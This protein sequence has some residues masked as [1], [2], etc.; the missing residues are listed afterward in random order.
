MRLPKTTQPT[1]ESKPPTRL[2]ARIPTRHRANIFSTK[3]IPN[4]A[5]S[6]LATCAGDGDVK[7]LDIH[8]TSTRTTSSI[9]RTWSCHRDRAK[10]LATPYAEQHLLWSC[11][12]DGTVRQFDIRSPHT[13]T[14]PRTNCPGIV[15]DYSKYGMELN[16]LSLDPMNANYFA[17]AGAEPHIF[18]HDRR[19][20]KVP[21]HKYRPEHLSG[22]SAHITSAK[23]SHDGSEL[24]GSWS[25][26][27]VYL[28]DLKQH[29][30][31]SSPTSTTFT[32]SPKRRH[33]TPS[34]PSHIKTTHP[35][36]PPK[37]LSLLRQKA[38]QYYAKGDYT[39]A[40]RILSRILETTNL[41]G[42]A[43]SRVDEFRRRR[44][45]AV[46]YRNRCRCW[47]GM[48]LDG[49]GSDIGEEEGRDGNFEVGSDSGS[50]G[51]PKKRKR[52]MDTSADGEEHRAHR[53][54]SIPSPSET[55]NSDVEID[56]TS[57][58]LDT[59]PLTTSPTPQP[60]SLP[61]NA[62][63]DAEKSL[64][65]YRWTPHSF[66]LSVAS[67][68]ARI[69][70]L[71]PTSIETRTMT[72]LECVRVLLEYPSQHSRY[73]EVFRRLRGVCEGW[74]DDGAVFG[75]EEWREAF[76]GVDAVVGWE[77]SL[78]SVEERER[79]S[80][81]G[82]WGEEVA[83][84][85]RGAEVVGGADGEGDEEG[86]W[87]DRDSDRGPM[88]VV[89]EEEEFEDED[90]GEEDASGLS[91]GDDGDDDDGE[92]EE[93]QE[94][95]AESISFGFRRQFLRRSETGNPF[96]HVESTAPI[97][98]FKGAC[99]VQTVKDVNFLGHTSTHI[100]SGSDDGSL[101]IW[102]KKTAKVV[103][104]LR[105]DE[106]VVNV[107]QQHPFLGVTLAV[108]GI[109]D[110]VKVFEGVWPWS[111]VRREV[112][113]G[114]V[115]EGG[116]RRRRR[117]RELD[118]E[119]FGGGGDDDDDDDG[120]GDDDDDDEDD[121]DNDTAPRSRIRF[122]SQPELGS[123]LPTHHLPS[124]SVPFPSG[125]NISPS[126]STL[127]IPLPT[128]AHLTSSS[129]M[130]RV[131]EVVRGNEGRRTEAGRCH[132]VSR[133][134]LARI[135]AGLRSRGGGGGGS[136]EGGEGEGEGEGEGGGGVDCE[137]Q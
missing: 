74:M 55:T 11:S 75:R 9:R 129:L 45:R 84:R 33:S 17:V 36:L 119:L 56:I 93:E 64:S 4:T 10:R 73:E 95:E 126:T 37:N 115:L 66:L 44:E 35:T 49:G 110:S 99:N 83:G 90:E 124:L 26:D 67:T 111:G 41:K 86:E 52:D 102:D 80:E 16:S 82:V 8:Y 31:S 121:D 71:P 24:I 3:F 77:D 130:D 13:C 97:R 68:A 88:V 136:G 21:V 14:N 57:M 89:E 70:S 128:G 27:Y 123:A 1:N 76:A 104:V 81:W 78:D 65:L 7:L 116:E 127:S 61:H 109:D 58:D 135:V 2:L 106:S 63:T 137:V 39:R 23:I 108:S 114:G 60:E 29:N 47:L 96:S 117:R 91:E 132:L 122:R 15:V 79:E 101:L 53:E 85:L 43:K 20:A 28:F 125:F 38:A 133:R 134:M 51:S 32:T 46:D 105:G 30:S 22:S 50:V 120:G 12:E 107:V 40:I 103:Q 34:P 118:E 54:A 98:C 19:N 18:Y 112:D 5:N 92:E 25:N 69:A 131:G 59:S 62:T 72:S 6:L 100:A 113:V 48:W 87:S 42:S 94:S